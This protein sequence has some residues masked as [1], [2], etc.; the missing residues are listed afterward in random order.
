MRD[1]GAVNREICWTCREVSSSVLQGGGAATWVL[2]L[3]EV[4]EMR[5]GNLDDHS[6]KKRCAPMRRRE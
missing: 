5:L 3:D 4:H 6:M 2:T 1:G